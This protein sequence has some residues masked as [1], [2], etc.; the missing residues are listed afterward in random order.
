MLVWPLK[1]KK[2]PLQRTSSKP[3]EIP[4]PDRNAI[5]YLVRERVERFILRDATI[6]E[7]QKAVLLAASRGTRLSHP[8]TEPVFRRIVEEA[9][10]ERKH[11]K[12]KRGNG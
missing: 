1:A 9:V 4:T 10:R 11:S 2:S 6:E 7:F 3:R 12:K 8:L 5:L